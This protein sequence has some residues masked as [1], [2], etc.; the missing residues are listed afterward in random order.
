MHAYHAFTGTPDR[1]VDGMLTTPAGIR[2][3]LTAYADLGVD[4]VMLY[5]YGFAPDQVDRLADVL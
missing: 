1:M 3:A 4:E 2:T 5:C